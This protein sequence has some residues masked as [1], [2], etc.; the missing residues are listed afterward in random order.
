MKIFQKRLFFLTTEE[1]IQTA[2]SM[3]RL[4]AKQEQHLK[5]F[6]T[7]GIEDPPARRRSSF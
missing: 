7:K 3:A 6:R 2:E 5:V 4:Q 1:Y